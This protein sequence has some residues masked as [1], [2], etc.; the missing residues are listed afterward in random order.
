[1]SDDKKQTEQKP[2]PPA[3]N[4]NQRFVESYSQESAQI[5]KA[6]TNTMPPPPNPNR[7]G[8]KDKK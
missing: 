6:V 2:N 3:S 7:G 5:D 4:D 8:D 1:M